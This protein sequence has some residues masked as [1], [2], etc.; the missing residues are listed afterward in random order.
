MA[1]TN[2]A[3]HVARNNGSQLIGAGGGGGGGSAETVESEFTCTATET[4]GDVV[5]IFGSNDVRQADATALSTSA[6]TVGIIISKP[7][8]TTCVVVTDGE[9]A[10]F[11][12][13]TPGA[14]YYVAKGSP[15][16][17]TATPIT[18]PGIVKAVG[19]AK[20]AT[21]LQVDIDT[22]YVELV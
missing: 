1:R 9:A 17:I 4:V 16:D 7:T 12:G 3:D 8:A 20:N 13:L 14:I 22:D 15:G 19:K 5:Y 2:E 10:V 21:T 11:G 6:A 18:A